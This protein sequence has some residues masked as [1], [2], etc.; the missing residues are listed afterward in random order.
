MAVTKRER[1]NKRVAGLMARKNGEGGER[2]KKGSVESE[3][4]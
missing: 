4:K 2:N 1:E 3:R